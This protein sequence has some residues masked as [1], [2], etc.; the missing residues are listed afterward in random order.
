MSGSMRVAALEIR[1]QLPGVRS[2]KEKRSIVKGLLARVRQRFEVA[3][4]EVGDLD[5]WSLASLGFCAVGNDAGVLQSRLGQVVEFVS[6][7]GDGF[8]LDYRVEVIA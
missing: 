1:L 3:A 6:R 7:S 5:A 2:L 8:I 4:A